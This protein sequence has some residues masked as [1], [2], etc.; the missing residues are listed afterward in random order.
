MLYFQERI[1]FLNGEVGKV[2]EEWVDNNCLKTQAIA[3]G[4]FQDLNEI[5]LSSQMLKVSSSSLENM[6]ALPREE[7]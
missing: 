6:K 5:Y 1:E 2:K 7:S 4:K 3:Q